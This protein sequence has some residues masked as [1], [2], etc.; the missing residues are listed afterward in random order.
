MALLTS[1]ITIVGTSNRAAGST[2]SL[3]FLGTCRIDDGIA[4]EVVLRLLLQEFEKTHSIRVSRISL[5]GFEIES[6]NEMMSAV[7]CLPRR[8]TLS[9]S[10]VIWEKTQGMPL[11]VVEVSILVHTL[12]SCVFRLPDWL[13]TFLL[14][15]TRFSLLTRCSQ[16]SYSPKAR[17]TDGNGM[18]MKFAESL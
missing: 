4:E 18:L 10:Q 3:L 9:L 8:K 14:S 2:C 7:L 11:F 16:K 5:K 15:I 1:L 13:L 17:S 6:L 12:R